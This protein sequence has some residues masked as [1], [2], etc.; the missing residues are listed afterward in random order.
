VLKYYVPA[1][2]SAEPIIADIKLR[3]ERGGGFGNAISSTTHLLV[4]PYPES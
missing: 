3:K 2:T 4:V 1:D